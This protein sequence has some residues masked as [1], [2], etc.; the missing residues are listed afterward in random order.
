MKAKPW[1]YSDG[2]YNEC[3]PEEATHAEVYVFG[4]WANRIIDLSRWRWNKSV[5]KP[6]FTP[7]LV[8]RDGSNCCHVFIT[9][10]QV[11]YLHD[12]THEYV[13]QTLDLRDVE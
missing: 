13:G 11:R 10:G 3:T 2:V 1:K 9:D 12:C 5:D 8:T 4:P 6:T 7:S